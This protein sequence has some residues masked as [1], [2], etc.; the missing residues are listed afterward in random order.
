MWAVP[1]V[2]QMARTEGTN[3][4]QN[5]HVVIQTI[6][7]ERTGGAASETGG[8]YGHGCPQGG[9]GCDSGADA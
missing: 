4:I 6:G 5:N 8:G 3:L 1:E 2:G 7:T 9:A